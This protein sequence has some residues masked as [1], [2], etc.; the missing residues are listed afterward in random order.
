MDR[1]WAEREEKFQLIKNKQVCDLRLS[2]WPRRIFNPPSKA[3]ARTRNL[4][5][6]SWI[7]FCCA[8]MLTPQYAIFKK[9]TI[10]FFNLAY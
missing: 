8:M 1:I 2:S 4:M 7:H 5:I 9:N 6:S 10:Y 3:R